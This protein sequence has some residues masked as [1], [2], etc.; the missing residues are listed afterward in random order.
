MDPCL[1]I[2]GGAWNLPDGD[3]EPHREGIVA[4]LQEVW[5]GLEAGTSAL[6][7]VE[8]AV[9]LL[10]DDPAFNA[11]HGA[12]MS[13][14][15]TVELDASIMEGEGLRAGA[16]AAIEG[17]RHPIGVA[18]RVMEA[19][20]HVLLVGPGAAEFARR[21]GFE[22][23]DP[24]ELLLERERA[25]YRRIRGGD[26]GP[27]EREFCGPAGPETHDPVEPGSREPAERGGGDP[28][29]D[30]EL[31]TVGA[32]AL[33]SRGRV[34]AATSTGGTQDKARGRVGDSAII[35]A[36]TYADGR[37]GAVS[38]TGH[39]ESI[40]RVTLARW[41]VDRLVEGRTAQEAATG[42]V[43]ELARVDGR[44]GLIVV[45]RRGGGGFAYNTP[46]MARGLASRAAG[47]RVG[48]GGGLERI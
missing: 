2:H 15:G 31:G 32:V 20:E 28:A 45:D 42:A 43:G 34:A 5:P 35:G 33:D 3:V 27:V 30:G 16:V 17:I 10:E 47:L 37:G 22:T 29:E 7:A 23:C 25:R 4:V 18:R 12:R 21:Q 13:R 40:L 38:C 9:R 41:A 6:D 39:G 26:R 11:G 14:A 46:R 1:V 24:E 8:A 36:G 48:V 19:S 44:G